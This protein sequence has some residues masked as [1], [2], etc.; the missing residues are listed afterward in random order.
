MRQYII[1]ID[2]GTTNCT[3]SYIKPSETP[4]QN[5]TFLIEQFFIPQVSGPA[6][7]AALPSLPSFI[8]FPLKE[9]LEAKQVA[10]SW[11]NDR[12]YCVGAFAR[13]RG[14]EVPNLMVG[15]AK[16]WLSHSNVDRRAPILP[17]SADEHERRISPKEA[18]STLLIH[19]QEAWDL[20]FPQALFA[21]QIVLVTVPAS[22][23]PSARELILEAAKDAGYPDIVLL[24]E[25]QAA[26]YAWLYSHYE[27]WRK[28]LKIGEKVLVIDIG[29]G[30]TDFSLISVEDEQGNLSLKR[31]AVGDH[32]LLGGDNLDLALAYLVKGKL[33]E[34]GHAIDEWQMQSLVNA[35]RNAKEL[36]LGEDPPES[37]E[38][39]I[40]GRGSKLIGNT[41]KASISLNEAESILIEGFFPLISP[42]E[43]PV[44]AIKSGIQQIGLPYAQ[45]ARVTAQLAKFLS[46]SQ[47]S[48]G[49][50]L[51]RFIMPSAILFNGGTLK[52]KAIQQR[53]KDQLNQWADHFK[54]AAVKT[55]NGADLDFGVGCGAAYYGVARTGEALRIKSGINKSYFI[56]VEDAVLAVPGLQTPLKAIC[57]APIGMEEGTERDLSNREFSLLLGDL[58][59]FRFFSLN[60]PLLANGEKPDIGSVVKN[61]KQELMEL[62]PVETILN[63]LENDGKTIRVKLN[64]KVTELGILELWC[65]ADDG[66]KWKLEFDIRK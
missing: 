3:M 49:N 53:L 1:G 60:T 24:E 25:P 6:M 65:K 61:W 62:H 51:E 33:E 15:S 11:N 32:L 59:T 10:L 21:N 30:T 34:Q 18:C 7:Q 35:S 22:F 63:K 57:V 50:N 19:L 47:E 58:A 40:Q 39:T 66:R 5:G 14:A 23:D 36:L 20:Q 26:F 52:A 43:R 48:S 16:S 31:L 55:L 29:G 28:T 17:F 64:T 42:E 37:V 44:N 45:D 54:E 41:L 12:E 46:M 9:E 4:S 2:L 56:G 8:Y 38:I 13:N 27:D